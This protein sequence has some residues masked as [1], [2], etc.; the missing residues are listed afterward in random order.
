MQIN[1]KVVQVTG[2]KQA[3]D[4]A[5]VANEYAF[6][7]KKR[8]IE[9]RRDQEFGLVAT[10]QSSAAGG[11]RTFGGYQAWANVNVVNALV[12]PADYTAPTNNGGGVAG[13]YAAVIDADEVA[14]SLTHVDTA[15]QAIYEQGGRATRVMLSPSNRRAFSARAQ[16]AG[17]ST[18]NAGDGNVRRNID[19]KGRLVQAVEFY[20]SDF[21]D[22]M[23]VPNYIMGLAS[24]ISGIAGG[25]ANFFGF[26]YDPS[27]WRWVR[28][29][30][31]QE[32]EVGRL[33]D[34]VIGQIVEEATLEC[35]N[36][37]SSGLIIGLSGA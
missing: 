4:Q 16:A 9:M 24:T 36:P 11:T 26:V 27:F 29:R 23:I 28:L 25:G 17:S 8:G 32:I 30:P 13:T 5:G 2:T 31:L 15:M 20:R 1:S 35:R 12:A 3:V 37:A 6:Q 10:N 21:G 7:L 33:G 18:S 34:S 22:L 14:L 19:E